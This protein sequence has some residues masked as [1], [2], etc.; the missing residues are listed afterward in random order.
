MATD[1]RIDLSYSQTMARPSEVLAKK[2]SAVIDAAAHH[3]ARNLRVIGSVAL[4]NDR[5]DSDID[6]L[7]DF[8]QGRSL[9]DLMA[10]EEE[11]RAL[12]GVNVDVVSGGSERVGIIARRAVEL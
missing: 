3:G 12:L 10:L 11:L 7:V 2:R 9:F 6:L 4:G 5:S 1:A 8:D